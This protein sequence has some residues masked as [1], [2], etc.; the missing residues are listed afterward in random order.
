MSLLV[1]VNQRVYTSSLLNLISKKNTL[2]FRNQKQIK[3]KSL[4]RY[5]TC[6][7]AC[8]YHRA[9]AICLKHLIYQKQMYMHTIELNTFACYAFVKF[10]PIILL[11]CVEQLNIHFFKEFQ[12]MASALDDARLLLMILFIIELRRQLVFGVSED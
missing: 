1:G 6:V 11:D 4:Q 8:V 7:C 2:S 9:N 10:A 12:P 5:Q 3:R